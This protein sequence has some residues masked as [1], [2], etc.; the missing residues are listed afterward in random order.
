MK[1]KNFSTQKAK[2]GLT[3]NLKVTQYLNNK[4]IRITSRAGGH[5][6]GQVGDVLTLSNSAMVARTTSLSHGVPGGNT[7]Q[8]N[9]FTVLTVR[10]KEDISNYIEELK[11]DK[12][13]IDKSIA[14]E[15]EKLAYLN[16]V[17]SDEFNDNEFKAYSTL[18]L[19]ENK[20]LS[21]LDKA[22][23]IAKLLE[24]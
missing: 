24:Q 13:E 2:L 1:A 12:K 23:L 5:N 18:S 21:K 20:K 17:E 9:E 22:K 10:N 11:K 3:T 8:F 7:L 16:E 6:Y 15:K 19:L 14:V 4:R